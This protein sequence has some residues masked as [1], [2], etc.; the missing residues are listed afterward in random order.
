MYQVEQECQGLQYQVEVRNITQRIESLSEKLDT[1]S[2]LG[3][4]RENAFLTCE[5]THNDSLQ[6]IEKSLKDLGK[7]RTS[8][9][10]PS[11]CT[12]QIEEDVVAGIESTCVLSTVDYHGDPRRTG[13]DPIKAEV[14][15]VTPDNPMNGL[16]VKIS[17]CE[18]GTYKIHFRAHKS[19]RYGINISVFDRPIRDTPLYFDVTEHNNPISTY[20][21]RG[22]GKDEFMQPVAI[23][24]DDVDQT[25]YVLDTGNS[26]IK[27]LSQDLEFVKHITN[28]GLNGRS[29]TGKTIAFKYL[30]ALATVLFKELPFRIMV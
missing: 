21:L 24:V 8:T 29:C 17:D 15:L 6:V 18:D 1:A 30:R 7:V 23:A 25:V 20:G 9:T 13:G 26:R 16:P 11:L 5:F 10:F 27:V 22:S 19:G 4:P 14:L 28:E 12:A 3:D 2:T